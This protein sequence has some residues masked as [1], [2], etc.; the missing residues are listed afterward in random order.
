MNLKTLEAD[1]VKDAKHLTNDL[2]ADIKAEGAHIADPGQCG[3]IVRR[4]FDGLVF[5]LLLFVAMF[6]A[7]GCLGIYFHTHR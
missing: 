7:A 4:H 3:S 6:I 2:A 5:T 1:L